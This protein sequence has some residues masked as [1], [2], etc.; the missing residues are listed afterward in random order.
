MKNKNSISTASRRGIY[1]NISLL[2]L[3]ILNVLLIMACKSDNKSSEDSAELINR[4]KTE[5]MA[6]KEFTDT[7]IP[8]TYTEKIKNVPNATS[9]GATGGNANMNY[10]ITHDSSK[11]WVDLTQLYSDLEMT[12]R[13]IDDYQN[14]MHMYQ[15]N[16]GG[17]SPYKEIR[18]IGDERKKQLKSILSD[19]QYKK[20]QSIRSNN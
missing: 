20:F 16:L 18:S 2:V 6:S 17:A 9:N 10:L 14:A 11:D 3:L 19:K 7:S 1:T 13:Q 12:S 8:S 5:S 4:Q 15:K